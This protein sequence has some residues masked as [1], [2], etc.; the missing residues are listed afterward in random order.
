M[1]VLHYQF[2]GIVF[3]FLSTDGVHSSIAEIYGN[4]LSIGTVF[5]IRFAYTSI[6]LD[7]HTYLITCATRTEYTEQ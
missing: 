1:L 2:L 5:I 3:H 4:L 7:S 6:L